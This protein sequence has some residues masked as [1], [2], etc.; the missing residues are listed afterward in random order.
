MKTVRIN[1]APAYSVH[2]GAGLLPQCGTY[3]A[4]VHPL[5]TAVVVTDSCVDGLYSAAVTASLEKSGFRVVKFVFP[6]GEQSKN[7]EQYAALL[8][9]MAEQEVTR[10]D[11]I[12]ALGGGVVGDLAGFAAATYQ[13]GIAFVQLPTTLLAQIDSSVGGKTAVDLPQGKNLV[14]AFWQPKLVLCD[15]LC[16]DS[17]PSEVRADGLGEAVKYGMIADARL[18]EQLCGDG[19][20]RNPEAVITRCIQIK[21][22]AVEADELDNGRRQILNFGHTVGHAIERHSRFTI[23]HGHAVAMGMGVITRACVRRG[24]VPPETWTTL[25]QALVQNGLPLDCPVPADV[26]AQGAAADKKRRGSRITLVLPLE[27]GRCTLS[28]TSVDE[29]EAFFAD[30]VAQL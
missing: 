5:C 17:L 13:R 14:G 7:L 25:K 23:T 2:I 9:F 21:A 18:L 8:S 6:H 12:V 10:S 30:G 27:A 26:L 28:P 19:L 11:L 22:D 24:L 20:T 4:Q 15:P 16:L 29:L 3:I 1:T